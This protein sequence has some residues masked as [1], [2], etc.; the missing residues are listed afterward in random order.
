M[1]RLAFILIAICLIAICPCS[2]SL[3][4][5]PAP[6]VAVQ[7]IHCE[8]GKLP[9]EQKASVELEAKCLAG[10]QGLASRKGDELRLSVKRGET[11]TFTSNSRACDEQDSERCVKYYLVAYYPDLR[12]YVV[13]GNADE[14]NAVFVVGGVDGSTTRLDDYPHLAPGRKRLA[15]AYGSEVSETKHDIAIYEV[16]DGRLRLSWSYKAKDYEMWE[17]GGW[18]GDE[19]VKLRVTSWITGKRGDRELI[20]REA[21][22]HLA[23]ATWKLDKNSN[24]RR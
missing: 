8:P 17:F 19:H 18:N 10:M 16:E 14:S 15:T 5:T 12:I 1:R 23:G 13:E 24:R 11:K 22:L 4:Q 3:A 7:D 21:A 20:T 6:R 9:P 2:A